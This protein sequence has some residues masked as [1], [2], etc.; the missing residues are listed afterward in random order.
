METEKKVINKNF[1]WKHILARKPY[2][3]ILYLTGWSF[4]FPKYI[5]YI[6]NPS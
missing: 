5:K 6:Y 4:I 3:F 1:T 2:N